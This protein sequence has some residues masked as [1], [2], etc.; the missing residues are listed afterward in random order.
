MPSAVPPAIVALTVA[1][2]SHAN[3][4]GPGLGASPLD[5]ASG[6]TVEITTD[7][8]GLYLDISVR[9]GSTLTVNTGGIATT[10]YHVKSTGHIQVLGGG[11]LKTGPVYNGYTYVGT[12]PASI[13]ISGMGSR[14]EIGYYDPFAA[15]PQAGTPSFDDGSM[16][17]GRDL[18]GTVTVSNGGVLEII[19]AGWG[20]GN[21]NNYQSP[22]PGLYLGGSP[23]Y[24]TSPVSAELNGDGGFIHSDVFVHSLGVISPGDPDTLNSVGNLTFT[25]GKSLIFNGGQLNVDLNAPDVGDTL[26]FDAGGDVTFTSSVVLNLSLAQ[27]VLDGGEF[28]MDLII[29]AGSITGFN[30]ANISVTGLSADWQV[31]FLTIPGAGTV[32]GTIQ[33][34]LIPEP[35]TYALWGGVS[36]GLLMLLRRRKR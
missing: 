23:F 35:S 16:Y 36:L 12:L 10:T 32:N 27:N 21:N 20:T 3:A 8:T 2:V 6:Q 31:S 1:F 19:G 7:N 11:I 24:L 17:S 18:P 4:G 14:M 22:A 13:L 5:V 25:G 28:K 9:D 34:K 15:P 26:T 29:G 30:D 33:G